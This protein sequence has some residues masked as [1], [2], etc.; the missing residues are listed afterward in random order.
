MAAVDTH[1]LVRFLMRDD[2]AQAVLAERLIRQALA[3]GRSL[4]VPVTVTLEL[5]WVLRTRFGLGKPAMLQALANLLSAAEL[6]FDAERALEVALELYR[7]G[8][9]DFA[10]CVHV[11]LAAE[12]GEVPLWTFDKSAA[13]VAGAQALTRGAA[14]AG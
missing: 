5:E 9:A 12:A 3:S 10:D 8:G 7:R 6:R 2:A 13:K 14:L 4:F 1:V 11:A